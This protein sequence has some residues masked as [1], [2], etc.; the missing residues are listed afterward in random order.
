MASTHPSLF[1]KCTLTEQEE[2]AVDKDQ[3]EKIRLN[4]NVGFKT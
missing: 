3:L 4:H 2:S 1:L